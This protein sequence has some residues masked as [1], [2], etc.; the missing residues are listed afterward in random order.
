VGQ[1]GGVTLGPVKDPA[2]AQN[3]KGWGTPEIEIAAQAGATRARMGHPPW[4][5]IKLSF[6]FLITWLVRQGIV[7]KKLDTLISVIVNYNSI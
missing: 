3:A 7:K 2:F 4:T 5:T 6:L 1:G